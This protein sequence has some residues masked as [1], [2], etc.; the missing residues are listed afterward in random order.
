MG[1]VTKTNIFKEQLLEFSRF[2]GECTCPRMTILGQWWKLKREESLED[3]GQ[4]ERWENNVITEHSQ[5]REQKIDIRA[6]MPSCCDGE[7]DG[8]VNLRAP[9]LGSSFPFLAKKKARRAATRDQCGRG[10]FSLAVA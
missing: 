10:N 2:R 3:Q 9:F 5:P 1:S 6:K 7:G 4:L 8:V